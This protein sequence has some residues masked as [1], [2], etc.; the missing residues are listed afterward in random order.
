MP[1]DAEMTF[2][3]MPHSLFISD[4]HLCD[5]RANTLQLFLGFLEQQAVEAEKLYILGDLF[6]VWVGD[7]DDSQTAV[8]VAS[9]LKHLSSRGTKIYIMHGNRDFLI[10]DR[11]CKSSHATLL[12]DP[13]VI[14][15]TGKRLLLTHGDQLCTRDIAYQKARQMLSSQQWQDDF[16][17][18]PL[19]ERKAIAAD[20]RK[21]STEATSKL[22]DD[23]MDVTVSEVEKW[24]STYRADIMIHGHTH[25][26]ATHRHDINGAPRT[27]IV[28]SEWHDDMAS[29]LSISD[30]LE[31]DHID[32]R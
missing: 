32:I 16:L 17:H 25:Q 15:I 3:E 12:N 5:E 24:F 9:A 4:L 27:R 1:A 21:Q 28:L 18:K 14:E 10:G 2:A 29:A 23:I 11:F 8:M 20:Y 30:N 19:N 7:D 6:D 31:I 13:N 22:S 26:P